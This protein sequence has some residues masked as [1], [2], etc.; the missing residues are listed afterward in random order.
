MSLRNQID[1]AKLVYLRRQQ[2]GKR[3]TE[4]LALSGIFGLLGGTMRAR[5]PF[6]SLVAMQSRGFAAA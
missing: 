2:A 1:T 5:R 3:R 4:V 6:V